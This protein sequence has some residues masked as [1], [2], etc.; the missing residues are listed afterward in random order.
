MVAILAVTLMPIHAALG[1]DRPQG[2]GRIKVIA[3]DDSLL[4]A[5]TYSAAIDPNTSLRR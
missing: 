5:G 4:D 1:D 3:F 2:D